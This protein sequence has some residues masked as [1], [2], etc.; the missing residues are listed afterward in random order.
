M[1]NN[2]NKSMEHSG[3]WLDSMSKIFQWKKWYSIYVLIRVFVL[4]FSLLV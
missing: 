2:V 3:N 1:L 4:T